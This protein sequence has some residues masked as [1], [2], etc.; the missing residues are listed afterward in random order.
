M[1]CNSIPIALHIEANIGAPNV[2]PEGSTEPNPQI[3][4]GSV[5]FNT[6]WT[7]SLE[8][9]GDFCYAICNEKIRLEEEPFSTMRNCNPDDFFCR[10]E[11]FVIWNVNSDNSRT[12]NV[13]EVDANSWGLVVSRMKFLLALSDFTRNNVMGKGLFLYEGCLYAQR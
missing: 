2:L 7:D 8:H 6:T 3:P 4:S 9:F 1:P 12:A 5:A 13:R 10:I 11:T